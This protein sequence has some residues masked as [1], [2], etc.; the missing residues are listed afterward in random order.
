MRQKASI[1]VKKNS[2]FSILTRLY[3]VSDLIDLCYKQE[4]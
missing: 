2:L 4:T 1:Q 3:C